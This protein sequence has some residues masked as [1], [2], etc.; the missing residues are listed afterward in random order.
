MI[1]F[2]SGKYRYEVVENFSKR[3]WKWPFVECTDVAV[4]KDDSV[5]VMNCG[6][7]TAVMTLKRYDRALL[8]TRHCTTG[9][10]RF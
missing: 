2:G 8:K 10:H 5:Y 7:Y 6:P 4:D 1:M 9:V 3:P